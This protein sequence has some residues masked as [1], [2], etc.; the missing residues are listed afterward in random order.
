MVCS[1][2]WWMVGD[3]LVT[4]CPTGR[5][6]RR[7]SK[8]SCFDDHSSTFLGF[9]SKFFWEVEN[10][11]SA[12][13]RDPARDAAHVSAIH[14]RCCY[15]QDNPPPSTAPRTPGNPIPVWLFRVHANGRERCCAVGQEV[16][17]VRR[18]ARSTTCDGVLASVWRDAS[19][20]SIVFR[21]CGNACNLCAQR[22][23][24]CTTVNRFRES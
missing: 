23:R 5:G 14:R 16:D 24:W 21:K 19:A 9:F 12:I 13:A 2:R 1:R 6:C 8:N 15:P 11:G 7:F 17:V 10:R 4:K 18:S 20:V 22:F 3:V